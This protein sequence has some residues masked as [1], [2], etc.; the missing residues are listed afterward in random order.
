[1]G[2]RLERFFSRKN[3]FGRYLHWCKSCPVRRVILKLYIRY[4]YRCPSTVLIT[5]STSLSESIALYPNGG[6]TIAGR[7]G[8]DISAYE[9]NFV[10]SFDMNGNLLWETNFPSDT[11]KNPLSMHWNSKR[12]LII[13]GT[14]N[15]NCYIAAYSVSGI[16]GIND[17]EPTMV[18]SFVLNQNYPWM[19]YTLFQLKNNR[20]QRCLTLLWNTK[21]VDLFKHTLILEDVFW[22][23]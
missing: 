15:S 9:G 18:N 14:H 22:I 10:T 5:F 12:E 4:P 16:T 19:I 2:G 13:A 23:R 21:V 17:P 6:C 20:I 11:V 7:S 3:T 8:F 1:M